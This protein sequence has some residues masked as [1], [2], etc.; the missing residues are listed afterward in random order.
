MVNSNTPDVIP[1]QEVGLLNASKGVREGIFL[2]L[3]FCFLLEGCV[4]MFCS[5]HKSVEM[6]SFEYKQK[7]GRYNYTT[8]TSYLELLKTYGK[9]LVEK[10]AQVQ[11]QRDR[12]SNGVDKLT[13]TGSQV[14]YCCNLFGCHRHLF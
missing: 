11:H 3:F 5:I 10:R 8:P 9:T 2:Y 4:E 1:D 7:L 13:S 6:K 12:L 14:H